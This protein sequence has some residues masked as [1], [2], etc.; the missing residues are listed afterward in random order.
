MVQ[1]KNAVDSSVWSDGQL[2]P[3]GPKGDKGD[4]GDPG[5]TFTPS[6]SAEGVISW[7]NNGGG[8]T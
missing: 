5:V 1:N 8:N 6:V 2:I 4:K 3:Y 7:T